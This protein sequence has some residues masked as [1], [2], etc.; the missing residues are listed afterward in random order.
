MAS[1]AI[2]GA[3]G[4]GGYFGARLAEAGHDVTFI[5]RGDHLKA[6][7]A[8][9]LKVKCPLG[10]AH[11]RPA[12]A[13]DDPKEIG[14]VDLVL[15]ATKMTALAADPGFIAPMVGP[16]TMALT[17]QNGVE[18]PDIL[19]KAIGADRVLGGLAI[20]SAHIL[21]P[22]EIEH[23]G[24]FARIEFGSITPA[25]KAH[26]ADVNG[27]LNVP[28]MEA[29]IARDIRE[30]LWR[31]FCM[32]ATGSG[33][34]TATR[35]TYGPL[36]EDPELR[37][38]LADGVAEAQAVAKAEGIELGEDYVEK[39]VAMI[40]G[41]PKEMNASMAVDRERGNPLELPWFSGTIVRLG[42]QHGVPTPVHRF[43]W[44]ILKPYKDGVGA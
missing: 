25:G 30:S 10:D 34:L 14:P 24:D 36:R 7:R 13:A 11:I 44:T 35:I 27:W 9:G 6:I 43:L 42:E 8:Q 41:F 22:G 40:D 28:G 33:L 31:K 38:L 4:I 32:L 16:E 39:C 17:T 21:G 29:T 23:V 20:I 37:Q 1:I 19:A 3:G 2:M 5:A 12:R 15:H 18:A 26:E